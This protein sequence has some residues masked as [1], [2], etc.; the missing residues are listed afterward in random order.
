MIGGNTAVEPAKSSNASPERARSIPAVRLLSQALDAA[1]IRYCHWKS[2]RKID[3]A[4]RGETDLD[5]LVARRDAARFQALIASLGYKPGVGQASPSICH[6]YGLDEVSG[7]LVHLHV[8]YRIVTGGTVLKNHRLPLEDMLL[9]RV[10]RVDELYTPDRA[11]ELVCF[12]IRKALEYA[13]PSE[14]LFLAR[15]GDAVVTELAWL[16]ETVADD[17]VSRLLREHLPALPLAVFLR[18]RE[19]IASGSVVRRFL[20]CRRLAAHLRSR[21]RYRRPHAAMIRGRRILARVAFAVMGRHVRDVLLSGGAVIAVVGSDGAGKSTIVRGLGDW[22]AECLAVRSIHA[23]KP[24]PAWLTLA[25]RL[26]L[27]LLRRLTPGYRTTSVEMAGDEKTA[28]GAQAL[29]GRRLFFLYPLRALMLAYERRRLLVRAHRAASRGELVLCDRYPTVQPG[30]PEGPALAFLAQ[31]PSRLYSWL[32][33]VE[34][35]IYRTIPPPDVVL[36]L[37]VPVDLACHR[38][39]TRDKPGG[40]KP[41]NYIRLRHA[42][43]TA[44]TFP[45]VPV[46]SVTTSSGIEETLR[47]VKQIVWKAL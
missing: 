47:S 41:G 25:P 11:A 6:Y 42:Q 5:L 39:L 4:L 28:R 31:D 34:A 20:A 33:R 10:Q 32:A 23:G 44:L 18:C 3:E 7:I 40:P 21:A 43:T 14:A 9:G 8:Y 19:A 2:N 26:L 35:D 46:H 29:R 24:P 38:N 13:S 15:E 45:G 37:D 17:D 36:H 22:L 27:P 30:V 1:G 16:R 12:V